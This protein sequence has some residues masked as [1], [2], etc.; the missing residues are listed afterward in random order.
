MTKDELVEAVQEAAGIETKAMAQRAVEAVFGTITD[1]LVKGAGKISIV[2]F[3]SFEK[4]A[5]KERMG[6][7][8]KTGDKIKIAASKKVSFKVGKALK[9]AV[10]AS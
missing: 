1:V 9:D 10:K 2:G 3:G 5:T 8:P 4:K 6:V 7:N